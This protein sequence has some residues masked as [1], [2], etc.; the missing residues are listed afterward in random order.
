[1]VGLAASLPEADPLRTIGEARPPRR[2]TTTTGWREVGATAVAA[3]GAQNV[4]VEIWLHHTLPPWREATKVHFHLDLGPQARRDAPE[5][6]RRAA[7]ESRLQELPTDAIW[8]WSD[9]SADGGVAN[10]GG[11]ALL[12]PPNEEAR[13]IRVP[14]G[15][16]CS[17]TRA[18]LTALHAALEAIPE[19]PQYEG[20]TVIICL[21]SKAA[22][23]L[24]SGGA[25]SQKSPLA[26]RVWTLLLQLEASGCT[27]HLQWVPS[28][29]GLAENDRADALA[30]E[31]SA[32]PQMATPVDVRTVTRAVT[33]QVRKTWQAGWP[34]G[35]YRA[36]MG[37]R[38]PPPIRVASREEAIDVH[39]LRAGHWGR[40]EQYL[41][42]IG[43]R[44]T[45]ECQQCNDTD[46]PAG[47]CLICREAADTPAHILL[48]CPSLCGRRLR[49]LGNI[50]ATEQDMTNDDVVA[51]LAAGYT[52]L[53]SRLATSPPRR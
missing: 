39:Q 5:E 9:G 2:L 41:H 44:P 13:E 24:L 34:E 40:S 18:E 53:K 16:L 4:P 31:A 38:V 48:H 50:F 37:A 6:M 42:R 27:L 47:L 17:S 23:L 46:C 15:R 11:G 3:A 25:A 43:R 35:W 10:G 29:C 12:L 52:A 20:Q 33:R 14:A 8:I 32:L 45:D 22:L 30:K 21:D 26:A 49:A 7:A 36:V 28:H 1:M 51:T 19:I